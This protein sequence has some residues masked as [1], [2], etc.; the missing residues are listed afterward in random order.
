MWHRGVAYVRTF[1]ATDGIRGA[2][3]WA[4]CWKGC[5]LGPCWPDTQPLPVGVLLLPG[6]QK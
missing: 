6:A 3:L 1:G 5:V 2:P 4:A